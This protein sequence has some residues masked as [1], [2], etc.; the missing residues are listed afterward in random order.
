MGP[1]VTLLNSFLAGF[2]VG[3]AI[4]CVFLLGYAIGRWGKL[5]DGH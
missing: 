1:E 2:V 4:G 3:I 5:F